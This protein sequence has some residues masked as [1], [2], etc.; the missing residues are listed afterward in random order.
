MKLS[1]QTDY[2]LRTL[3]FLAA[4]PGRRNIAEIADFFQISQ[5]HVAKVV[6]QL[7]RG[8]LVRSVRGIGGGLELARTPEQITIG[9]VVRASEGPTH[10]LD[11]VAIDDVCVIQR[12]CK[13]RSVLAH[14]ERVQMDYLASVRLCDVLPFKKKKEPRT[15]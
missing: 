9:E 14:A 10:L 3:M 4:H 5:A 1:L 7:A 8:G 12:S 2:S 15:E 11:C 6:T 13:L